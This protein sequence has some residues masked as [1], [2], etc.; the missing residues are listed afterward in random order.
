MSFPSHHFE[1]T[2]FAIGC[3]AVAGSAQQ[4]PAQA[5]SVSSENALTGQLGTKALD[6]AIDGYPG[7]YTK[8]WATSGQ[9]SGAWIQLSWSTPVQ[10]SRIALWDRPNLSDNVLAGTLTFSDGSALAVGALPSN[11]SSPFVA[12]FSTKSITWV[13]FTII[14][15]TGP[16]IGLSE[17]QVFGPSLPVDSPT[18]TDR[19]PFTRVV[20]DSN[21]PPTVLEKGLA[22][23]DGDGRLD[24]VIG[25]GNPAG[26]SSG[27]GLAW[28]QFPRSG[29]PNNTWVKHTILA[30]G[31]MYEELRTFDVNGDG[32]PDVIASEMTSWPN[33]NIYW[34]ENPRGRG[35]DPTTDAWAVHFIGTGSDEGNMALG[36]LDGD[37][38]TDLVTN[39]AVY[40]QNSPTSW[41]QMNLNRTGNGAALLDIGSGLGAVNIVAVGQSPFPIVW[42]ENPREHGGNPRSDSWIA[43]YIGPGYD[44]NGVELTYATGDFNSDGRMDLTTAVSETCATFPILWWEA[45][46][47]RRNGA[48]TR[49][50][51]DNSYQCV[52]NL[53][54][55]DMDGD[56]FTD[57][58]AGEQEQSAQKR[59]AIFYGDG[60]GN[61]SQQVLST[62]GGHEQALGDVT[63]NGNLDI[64]NANHGWSGY[65]HPI[66]LYLNQGR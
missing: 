37:G 34:F 23:I 56:G 4:V 47:D 5:V 26:S 57:I 7:D 1:L 27:Q 15:A 8:E 2:L 52:H 49:H 32:A 50:T 55:A 58:V 38:R 35:G 24:A 40:F 3:L 28:Y 63:G 46:P 14:A 18:S 17:F 65:P 11:A 12:S 42:L 21:P 16:N 59:L 54:T 45:P 10:V 9:R 39:T 25:F 62:H 44:S 20:I 36:D 19:A 22:D 61:F 64:L 31:V 6:G 51:I 66:E 41:T 29:N 30:S 48:W 53:K 43:H 13:K 33:T 60:A